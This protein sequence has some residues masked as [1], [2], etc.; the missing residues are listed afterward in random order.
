M[1]AA[2]SSG[3]CMV[4]LDWMVDSYHPHS[5]GF[6]THSTLISQSQTS[7]K[8]P[9]IMCNCNTEITNYGYLVYLPCL[10]V[11]HNICIFHWA[12]YQMIGY[13]LKMFMTVCMYHSQITFNLYEL[14]KA[15]GN[16]N[17]QSAVILLCCV[18]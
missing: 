15:Q 3:Q 13:F 2:P 1:H 16:N 7:K 9:F 17:C 11:Y 5:L 6:H 8:N 4:P 18:L 10:K 14:R 12:M